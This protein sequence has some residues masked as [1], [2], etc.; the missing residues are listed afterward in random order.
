MSLILIGGDA[1]P[2]IGGF[3][4]RNGFRVLRLPS[5]YLLD[6]PVSTHP[7]ILCFPLD[8]KI[9]MSGEYFSL[10]HGIFGE[11]EDLVTTVPDRPHSPYPYDVCFDALRVGHH[12]IGSEKH[13]SGYLKERFDV[14]HVNQ[15][16]A[17]CSAAR[18]SDD[19]FITA[20][21][22]IC[23]AL[24]SLGKDVLEITPGHVLLDG[25]SCGFIGG[26]GGLLDD[27]TYLFFGDPLTHPDGEKMLGFAHGHNI[28]TASLQGRLRDCGSLTCIGRSVR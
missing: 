5:F 25:Y 15:G 22:G 28:K 27:G 20:D 26:A 2:E 7:D 1:S 6:G 9:V 21:S 19:A 8:G 3:L 24:R 23:R 4:S 17:R 16:Y 11:I 10:N 12:L 13:I 14:I 18:L